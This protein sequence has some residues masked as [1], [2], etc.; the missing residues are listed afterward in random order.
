LSEHFTKTMGYIENKLPHVFATLGHEVHVVTSNLQVYHRLP[1]YGSTY[2]KFQGPALQPCGVEPWDEY[3]LHRLPHQMLAGY[4]RLVG[5]ASY[6]RKLRPDIVQVH[7]TSSWLPLA[8]ALA[9]PF[10]GYRLFTGTHQTASAFSPAVK[11]STRWSLQRLG[12]DLRR[13]VPGRIVSM[14]AERCYAA[15][16]DCGDIAVRYYGVPR[17]QVD[18][19]PLG[20]DTDLFSPMDNNADLRAARQATRHDLG[21]ESNDL[22]CIYTGR[23]T[24]AKNPLLLARAVGQLRR[25]GEPFR[26]LFVGGGPQ[27]GEIGASDGCVLRDFVPAREL[28]R[29]YRAADIGVW[30]KYESMSMLDAAACGL[31]IV[32]NHTVLATERFNGNGLTYQL[33]DVASLVETLLRLGDGNLRRTLGEFGAAK[34]ATKFSWISI[35]KRRLGDYE[36]VLTNRRPRGKQPVESPGADKRL[37]G[38]Q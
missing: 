10:C 5:L 33:G 13:A 11:A 21:F 3:T 23:M 24:A 26:A 36:T 6:L 30:P 18:V 31:P 2:E 9:R 22:V 25:K 19:C 14:F 34:V 17:Q 20:V 7:A 15:T 4:V 37:A 28:P 12:S 16:G 38:T 8:A 1:E 32:V 29:F 35:A 27:A